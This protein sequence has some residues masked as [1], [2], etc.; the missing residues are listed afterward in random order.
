VRSRAGGAC[1][2]LDGVNDR[3]G[4]E[5]EESTENRRRHPKFEY[6]KPRGSRMDEK[7]HDEADDA[8]G[9]SGKDRTD[10]RP[11]ENRRQ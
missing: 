9:D 10:R 2:P 11:S 7:A 8:A 1:R 3:A 5:P 4:R 6:G